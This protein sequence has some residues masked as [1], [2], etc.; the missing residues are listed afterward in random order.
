MAKSEDALSPKQ[1]R[2]I[3]EYLI[4]SNATQ[5]AIRAGYSK[6]T[7][8]A[9]GQRLLTNVD[10]SAELSRQQQLLGERANLTADWVLNE[11]ME[12]HLLAKKAGDLVTSNRTLELIGKHLG[13]FTG[14]APVDRPATYLFITGEAGTPGRKAN[15]IDEPDYPQLDA[16]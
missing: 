10:I 8:R 13:M 15:I 1:R 12:N 2:F 11:L 9:Q 6:R 16:D 14:K 7:A 5:A 4:D 3:E